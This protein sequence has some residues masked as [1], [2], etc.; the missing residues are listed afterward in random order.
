MNST[1]PL[2]R[3]NLQIYFRDRATVM[4]SLLA[5]VIL[6]LLY[7]LVLGSLQVN[8]LRQEFPEARTENIEWFVGSWV[9][10]GIVMITTVSTGLAALGGL[11]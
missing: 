8:S 3:R 5:A 2:V 11:R 4:L 1:L 9:Y 7:L 6:L 10:A